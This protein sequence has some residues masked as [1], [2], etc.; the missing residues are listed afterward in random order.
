M[1]GAEYLRALHLL[2]LNL[3]TGAKFLRLGER[4]SRR[5]AAGDDFLGWPRVA[6]LRLMIAQGISPQQVEMMM[7]DFNDKTEM[8]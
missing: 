6:L 2:G 4:N 5:I 3:D 1:T 7:Q 8:E